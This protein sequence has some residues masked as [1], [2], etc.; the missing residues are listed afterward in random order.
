MGPTQSVYVT[1]S[2]IF[3]EEPYSKCTGFTVCLT[4]SDMSVT[5]YV[6]NNNNNNDDGSLFN[7]FAA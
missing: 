7:L 1:D 5:I 3:V 4:Y 6:Y 2:V